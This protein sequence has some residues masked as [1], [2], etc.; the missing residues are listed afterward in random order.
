[1][2]LIWA[3][4][5]TAPYDNTSTAGMENCGALESSLRG[6]STTKCPEPSKTDE[7]FL[8]GRRSEKRTF[9]SAL[10]SQAQ[11]KLPESGTSCEENARTCLGGLGRTTSYIGV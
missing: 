9:M 11:A 10:S 1:M 4:C 3:S 6:G 2:V 7:I 5:S 8:A